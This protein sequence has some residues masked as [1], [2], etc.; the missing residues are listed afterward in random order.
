MTEKLLLNAVGNVCERGP[1]TKTV[2]IITILLS[3]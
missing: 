2:V 3:V 1:V